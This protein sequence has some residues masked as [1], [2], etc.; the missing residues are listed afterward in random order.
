[1]EACGEAWQGQ[2]RKEWGAARVGRAFGRG[3]A[4]A[5]HGAGGEKLYPTPEGWKLVQVTPGS[6]PPVR[7]VGV[8][9]RRLLQLGDGWEGG[10]PMLM[11]RYLEASRAR[12]HDEE[13]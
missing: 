11:D 5:P 10:K 4:R 6:T 8:S 9:G 12:R 1:M 3:R 13:G 2:E 7:E